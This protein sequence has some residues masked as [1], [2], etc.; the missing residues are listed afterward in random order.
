MSD[1]FDMGAYS[2]YVW[3][4]FGLFLAF[5]IWDL[6]L[7][8]WRLRRLRREIRLRTRREAARASTAADNP[9]P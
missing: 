9:I 7:P 6:L 1:L 8:V 5:L 3:T 4:C 2:A